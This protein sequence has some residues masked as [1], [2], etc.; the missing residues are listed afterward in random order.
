MKKSPKQIRGNT[1]RTIRY[2]LLVGEPIRTFKYLK[3]AK[4][5][6]AQYEKRGLKSNIETSNSRVKNQ[7]KNKY[8]LYPSP[9]NVEYDRWLKAY[10]K[11]K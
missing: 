4:K 7:T 1:K 6:K 3:D 9:Y 2:K 10:P 11:K 5:A 8:S